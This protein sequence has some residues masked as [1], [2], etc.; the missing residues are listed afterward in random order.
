[1]NKQNILI[2]DDDEGI[3]DVMKIVLTEKGYEV[4]AIDNGKEIFQQIQEQRP[5][6]ILIDFWMPGITGDEVIR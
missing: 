3:V 2:C 6:L 4:R 1:M 5:D